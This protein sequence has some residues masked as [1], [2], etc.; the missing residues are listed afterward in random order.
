MRPRILGLSA[1]KVVVMLY[2]TY[3]QD[4]ERY[5]CLLMLFI[6]IEIQLAMDENSYALAVGLAVF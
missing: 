5:V 3:T 6:P 2:K 1:N 4:V